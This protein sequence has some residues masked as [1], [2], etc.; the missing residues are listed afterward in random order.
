M[1]GMGLGRSGIRICRI[2]G[3]LGWVM[4]GSGPVESGITWCYAD[5]IGRW[6]LA[7]R[8]PVHMPQ[9]RRAIGGCG[10]RAVRRFDRHHIRVPIATCPSHWEGDAQPLWPL[11]RPASFHRG[12]CDRTRNDPECDALDYDGGT[13]VVA[14]HG[15]NRL[16]CSGSA[17]TLRGYVVVKECLNTYLIIVSHP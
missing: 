3:S 4:G 8:W 6:F 17:P 14:P 15:H 13:C 10:A 5:P 11:A 7:G 2:W 1:V 9:D 12:M 16:L